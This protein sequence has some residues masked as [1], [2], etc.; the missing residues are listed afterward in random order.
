LRSELE[1]AFSKQPPI[2]GVVGGVW[3]GMGVS[4]ECPISYGM[5]HSKLGGPASSLLIRVQQLRSLHVPKAAWLHTTH[6]P[7][8]FTTWCLSFVICGRSHVFN[9]VL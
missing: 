8:L 4:L 5:F 7:G 3:R 6:T 2:F 9:L 1:T